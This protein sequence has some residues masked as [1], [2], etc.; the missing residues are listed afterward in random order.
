[1]WGQSRKWILSARRKAGFKNWR[2]AIFGFELLVDGEVLSAPRVQA[3][4]NENNE[5]TATFVT[6]T[7]NVKNQ[8]RE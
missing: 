5:L 6:M 7:K 4:R 3:L 1:M 8:R 2:R